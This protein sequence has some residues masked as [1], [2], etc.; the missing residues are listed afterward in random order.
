M[1]F[2]EKQYLIRL[3]RKLTEIPEGSSIMSEESSLNRLKHS[4][5]RLNN[6]LNG[7]NHDVNGLNVSLNTPLEILKTDILNVLYSID[8]IQWI[9]EEK[10]VDRLSFWINELISEVLQLENNAIKNIKPTYAGSWDQRL[11]KMETNVLK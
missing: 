11:N 5:N 10:Q 9:I 8:I 4:Q 2:D 1:Q 6:S 3:K 7:A